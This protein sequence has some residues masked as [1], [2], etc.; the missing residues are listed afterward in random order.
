MLPVWARNLYVRL[1]SIFQTS[2]DGL[3]REVLAD[4]DMQLEKNKVSGADSFWKN[5]TEEG[6]ML[7]WKRLKWKR[8]KREQEQVYIPSVKYISRL[9]ENHG[10]REKWRH[11]K[12]SRGTKPPPF[13]LLMLPQEANKQRK[14]CIHIVLVGGQGGV[15]QRKGLKRAHP[16]VPPLGK[17]G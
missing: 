5:F 4:I 13:W 16:T 8:R 3:K 17:M 1:K 9:F 10:R 15:D 11:S 14:N 12:E 6:A 2:M 7:S